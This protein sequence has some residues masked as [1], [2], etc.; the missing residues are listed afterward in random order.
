MMD[1][2]GLVFVCLIYTAK[3]SYDFLTFKFTRV[4][5]NNS[6]FEKSFKN[7]LSLFYC[8]CILQIC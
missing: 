6:E 3:V 8:L 4:R 5:I 1:F 2:Y 7:K